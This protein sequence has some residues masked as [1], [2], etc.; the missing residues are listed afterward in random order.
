[1]GI[2]KLAIIILVI[3]LGII[4]IGAVIKLK[5]AFIG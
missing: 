1:M 5:N 2:R 3:A 4:F